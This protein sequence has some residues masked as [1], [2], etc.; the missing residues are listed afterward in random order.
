VEGGISGD[1]GSKHCLQAVLKAD[2]SQE[3]EAQRITFLF[4]ETFPL[5]PW[6][7]R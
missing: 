6:I 4:A 7:G 3:A 2:L 1:D 5:E